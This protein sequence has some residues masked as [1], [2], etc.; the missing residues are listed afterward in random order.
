MQRTRRQAVF[1]SG[2]PGSGKTS[3]AVP[4]AAELGFALVSKDRIKE[5]LHDAL[6]APEP[7]LAWSQALGAAAMEL[8]W[9]LA[10]D[11]PSVVVE[12][13]FRPHSPYQR[14]KL[15]ALADDPVEV[16]C[17]CDPGL[18]ARRY[19]DRAGTRHPVHVVTSLTPHMLAEYD[20]P[21]GIGELVTVDTAVP[22][23]AAAVAAA[24]RVC[25][26]GSPGHGGGRERRPW[27]GAGPAD[28][29]RVRG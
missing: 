25:L 12:A 5:T 16:Y 3:L 4:L 15:A 10:A 23:D 27:L 11:A 9:A 24:V 26:R 13:N 22:V 20:R 28:G 19:R 8:L 14:G 29:S 1:V 18:A 17:R 6:G 21:V 7:D 2:A